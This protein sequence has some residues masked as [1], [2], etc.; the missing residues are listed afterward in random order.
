MGR[1][2][3]GTE[4]AAIV[5]WQCQA[6]LRVDQLICGRC[7]ATRPTA[8]MRAVA[9]KNPPGD[10]FRGDIETWRVDTRS[11]SA[12]Y[13]PGETAAH[14]AVAP[15][16]EQLP[17]PAEPAFPLYRPTPDMLETEL[18]LFDVDL[19]LATPP[20][21]ATLPTR[22]TRVP[23]VLLALRRAF[24]RETAEL[25]RATG[26]AALG[27]L[28]GGGFWLGVALSAHIEAGFLAIALGLLVGNGVAIGVTVRR[29]RYTL[30]ALGLVIFFWALCIRLLATHQ[31]VW[32]PL[33]GAY[34]F[35]A[36]FACTAPV[37]RL[38]LRSFA[39]LVKARRSLM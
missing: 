11:R 13:I 4:R 21:P 23:P 15:L 37:D 30:Y 17:E 16:L 31:L 10:P 2:G 7:G 22:A 1:Q 36:L 34:L 24:F 25:W 39:R 20:T 19:T 33:D 6:R 29:R 5:C 27:A 14:P 28:I 38:P 32:T 8:Q 35:F 26:F 9:A 18:P 3:Y 12:A